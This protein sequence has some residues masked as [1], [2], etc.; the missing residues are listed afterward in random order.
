MCVYVCSSLQFT[1]ASNAAT[2]VGGCLVTNQYKLRLPAAFISAFVISGVI[3]PA[4]ARIVWSDGCNSLSPY[5]FCSHVYG[6]HNTSACEYDCSQPLSLGQRLYV[7]DFAGGGA[8]HLLGG[9]AGL[10]ICLFAKLQEVR[11][12]RRG[13]Q[14]LVSSLL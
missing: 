10:M 13:R 9:V 1:F 6:I 2:I 12:R 4:I 14:E 7:L 5:R 8:V 3:H 11:D